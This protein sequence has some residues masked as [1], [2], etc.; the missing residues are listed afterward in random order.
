MSVLKYW[1]GTSWVE[2]IVGAKGDTGNSGIVDVTSPIVN[3]GS[4]TSAIVGINDATT[5]QKGAVQLT[6]S[7]SSTSTT[8]AA[9]P[10]SVKSAYDLADGKV[11][12]I[13][14]APSDTTITIAGTTTAPTV[15][16]NTSV[17][18]P[19]ASPALTGTPTTPTA[20]VD[21][22]TT[23]IASTAFVVGQGYAKVSGQTFTGAITAPNI[24]DTGLSTSGIVTNTTGGLLGTVVSVPV[25]NG[26]TNATDAATARTNLGAI[27]Q[28]NVNG[29][30][31]GSTTGLDLYP[32]FNAL[33]T[34][35]GTAMTSG[36]IRT[37]TFVPMSN[38]SVSNVSVIVTNVK[39]TSSA[40]TEFG[41]FALAS[42]D[43]TSAY[44]ILART[45]QQNSLITNGFGTVSGLTT[46]ALDSTV[47]LTAGTTYA[48][49]FLWYSNGTITTAPSIAGSTVSTTISFA[50]PKMG[51]SS[52]GNTD[53]SATSVTA[54][55]AAAA[56]SWARLT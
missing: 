43:G 30:L 19:L 51:T 31:N 27:S 44:T 2:A 4:S 39:S 8:T 3:S 54:S 56:I 24:T 42:Y 46:I 33:G 36:I 38:I 53:I 49:L 52:T 17:I 35:A 41:R 45:A 37:T 40:T 15:K 20:A 6:D 1:N 32:K 7:T 29:Y 16:V 23:Q 22:N 25:A 28:S 48:I 55:A 14:N 21:T 9:T 5:S 34:T 18:A 13:S 11:S 26:G 47:N 50:N 10:N 12:S